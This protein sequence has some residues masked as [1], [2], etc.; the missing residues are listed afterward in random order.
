MNEYFYD[1]LEYHIDF[2]KQGTIYA[3]KKAWNSHIVDTFGNIIP[4]DI[5]LKL[6]QMWH[7][8]MNKKLNTRTGAPYSIQTKNKAHSCLTEFMQYLFKN[9]LIEL[10]YSQVIGNFKNPNENKNQV[11]KIRFQTEEQF[12]LFMSVVDDLFGTNY[13]TFFLAWTAYGRTKSYKN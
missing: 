9:G 5:A 3:Y 2:V 8:R 7:E 11:K 10:N 4:Q 1:F 13:L 6:T 12:N